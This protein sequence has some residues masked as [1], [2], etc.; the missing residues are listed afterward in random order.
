[1]G[2]GQ[3]ER[4][5]GLERGVASPH[6]Q[7]L[8]PRE[9][10][11][12][13]EA[14]V[15]PV[16]VLAGHAQ[17]AEVPA[18][19][20]RDQ[21]AARLDRRPAREPHAEIST[22]P[23]QALRTGGHGRDPRLL[24]LRLQLFDQLLF[25]VGGD[26]ELAGRLHGAR[27]GVDGLPLREVH[28]GREGLRRLED[29]EAQSLLLGLDRRGHARNARANDREIQD[30]AIAGASIR[31][32]RERATRARVESELEERD[33]GQIPGDRGTRHVRGPVAARLGELLH[34]SG[35][36][37]RVEPPRVA[38]DPM[39]HRSTPAVKG[40]TMRPAERL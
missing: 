21:H 35:R 15:H 17:F 34:R 37:A 9:I 31:C 19:S 36:P 6:D 10:L 26:L 33:P 3:N 4:D 2:A 23:L 7:S 25:H 40:K 38:R 24:G 8:L 29:L 12:V 27:I 14:V 13:M 28:E 39:R 32:R 16:E 5:R 11:G 22:A 20:D 30:A 18:P 1:M